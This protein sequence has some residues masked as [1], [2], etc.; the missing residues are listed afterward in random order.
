LNESITAEK[1]GGPHGFLKL[2]N[3]RIKTG[4]FKKAVQDAFRINYEEYD[5]K[6]REWLK[7]QC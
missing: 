4:D 1:Y 6:W 2:V 3:T 7:E 5:Q